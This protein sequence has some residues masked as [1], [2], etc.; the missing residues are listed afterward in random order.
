MNEQITIP[1]VVICPGIGIGQVMLVD[2]AV[3]VP[4][5]KIPDDQI[6]HEQKRYRKAADAARQHVLEHIKATHHDL[7]EESAAIIAAHNAM[8]R[9]KEFHEG[10]CECIATKLQN[11]EWALE[12]EA[13]KLI[14]IFETMRDPFYQARAEDIRDMATS[15]LDLLVQEGEEYEPPIKAAVDQIIVTPHL[16]PSAAILAQRIGTPAFATESRAQSAHAAILLKGFNIPSIGGVEGLVELANEGDEIIVDALEGQ[17]ILRPDNKTLDRYI[18]HQRELRTGQEEVPPIECRTADG[19]EVRLQGNIGNPDQVSLILHQGLQGVG[20][21][22]TEFFALEDGAIPGEEEQV[23]IY[24]R[25]IQELDGRSLIV[26]T[27]DIGADKQVGELSVPSGQNPALGVRGIRRHLQG[28]RDELETQY[29]AILRAA[30]GSEIGIMIPMVTTLKDIQEAK[31]HLDK[32]EAN[33]VESNTPHA[34]KIRFGAM[35][36][37]PS[38]ALLVSDILGEVDFISLG[39]NDLLQYLM[40][41]DRDNEDVIDYNDPKNPAFTKILGMIISEA[42][43]LGRQNDVSICGEVASRRHHIPSLLKMGYRSFSISP[44]MSESIRAAIAG[45]DL[46]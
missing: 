35:I 14:V 36:E 37:T 12:S 39:T 3:D 43:R 17:V 23:E 44:V 5:Q 24:R 10:V 25:V 41:A 42:I 8:L 9:D 32:V 21:F 13:R 28:N 38:A 31:R 40:A 6:H 45:T 20:L 7:S 46:G 30:E 11:A 33:L 27:F 15:I 16:H 1:G 34:K 26:R 4:K 29:R 19:T 22:R 18:Q 2:T